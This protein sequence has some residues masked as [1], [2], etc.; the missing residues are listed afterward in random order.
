MLQAD[1]GD[2]LEH[3]NTERPYQGYRN[4]GRRPLDTVNQYRKTA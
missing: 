4:V 3:Y 2:W 1:L